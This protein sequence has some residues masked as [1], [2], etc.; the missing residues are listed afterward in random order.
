MIPVVTGIIL[1]CAV[2]TREHP[3]PYVLPEQHMHNETYVPQQYQGLT[4]TVA[5]T[6]GPIDHN[7]VVDVADDPERPGFKI[8]VLKLED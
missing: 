8:S 2:D 7:F 4:V 5:T 6:A 3:C 1:Y